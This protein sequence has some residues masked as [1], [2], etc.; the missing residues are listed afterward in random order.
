M[1]DI[2]RALLDGFCCGIGSVK[3]KPRS[4]EGVAMMA[5]SSCGTCAIS[6]SRKVRYPMLLTFIIVRDYISCC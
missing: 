4:S 1:F 5:S 2:D 6:D 3:V